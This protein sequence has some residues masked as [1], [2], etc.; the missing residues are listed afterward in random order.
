MRKIFALSALLALSGCDVAVLDPKGPIAAQDGQILV[1]SVAI[2]LAIVAPTILAIVGFAWWYRAGNPRARYRPDFEYSGQLELVVW[3]IP[4]LTVLLL[5]GVIWVGSHDLDPSMPVEGAGKPLTIQ[6]VSLDWKW[7]FIYPE[8]RIVSVNQLVAPVGRPLH[9]ELTSASVMSAF[10][11]PQ[12]GSMIYLMNGMTTRLNL[13]ADAAGDYLG[14]SS[15]LDGDGFSHMTFNA[16][17][18]AP[19]D[20]A[21]WAAAAA[22]PGFDAAAYKE[23]AKQGLAKPGQQPLADAA[24]FSDIA[25]QKLPP[26]PGPAPSLRPK[27]VVD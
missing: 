22:G 11:V 25:S 27:S 16:K 10:F 13:R 21:A 2:M 12:W 15:N 24:L 26:G 7:L 3:S 6:V 9:L 5:S 17:A 23:L 1:D 14:L 19:G 18:V 8:Q 20:F 4:A